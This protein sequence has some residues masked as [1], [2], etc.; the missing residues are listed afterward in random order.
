[1]QELNTELFKRRHDK[2][3][4]LNSPNSSTRDSGEGKKKQAINHSP[5]D[6]C[7]NPFPTLFGAKVDIHRQFFSVLHTANDV[8]NYSIA[9]KSSHK[10]AKC[11]QI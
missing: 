10:L 8:M 4:S 7:K 2:F 6:G 11:Q 5:F 9:S 3:I 1:M